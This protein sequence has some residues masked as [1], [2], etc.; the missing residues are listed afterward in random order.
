MIYSFR[1]CYYA[2]NMLSVLFACSVISIIKHY[3]CRC[4][5]LSF[6]SDYLKCDGAKVSQY[7]VGL[8]S[9]RTERA[10]NMQVMLTELSVT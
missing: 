8:S 6:S 7:D 10:L 9:Y 4:F 3:H 2:L 5:E 1:C